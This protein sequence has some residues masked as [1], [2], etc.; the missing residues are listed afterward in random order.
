MPK[1]VHQ[2]KKEK[3]TIRVSPKDLI[4]WKDYATKSNIP[5]SKIVR[6]TMNKLVYGEQQTTTKQESLVNEIEKVDQKIDDMEINMRMM[7]GEMMQEMK[8]NMSNIPTTDY[9]KQVLKTLEI[10]GDQSRTKLREL[11]DVDSEMINNILSNCKGIEFKPK[12]KKWG[13]IE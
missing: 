11:L 1:L 2:E 12:S 10:F 5:L 3:Y 9:E 6:N 13:L 7:L 4:A 8:K